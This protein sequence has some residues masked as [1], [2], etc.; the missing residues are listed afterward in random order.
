MADKRVLTGVY[1]DAGIIKISENIA[2]VQHLDFFTPI[3]DDPY[4]QGKIAACNSASDV[5]SKGATDIIGM[6]VI[7][8]CPLNTPEN[9]LKEMMRGFYDFCYSIKAPIVGG[10]TIIN[11]WPIM[12]GTATA[13]IEP[14]KIVYNSGAKPG[15]IL[16]L[17]KPLGT[18]PAMGILRAPPKD[19][20]AILKDISSSI[21][22]EAIDKAIEVMITPNKE[23][24]EAMVKVGVNAATDITGF[25]IL[26]HSEIMAKRSY[27]DIE[28]HSMSIIRGTIQLSKIF[29]YGLESGVSAE[30]SGGLLISVD[31]EKADILLSELEKMKFH[32]FEVGTVKKGLGN[33]SLSKNL[34]I[35]EV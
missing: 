29:G 7:L 30:T 31:K 20:K 11:P 33:A 24:A 32:A 2:V 19:Q 9:I 22:S 14:S 1:D 34:K 35:I 15:D 12:G 10:H 13:I 16:I 18:Q 5:F 4:I 8:G 3:I 25:G 23:A 6:L 27:V 21:I 17:S 26:G 28:I